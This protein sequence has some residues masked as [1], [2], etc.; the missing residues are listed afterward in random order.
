MGM[1]GLAK[2]LTGS[3]WVLGDPSRLIRI[4]LHGKEGEMLMPPFGAALADEEMAAVLTYI[5]R[6]WDHQ[7]S[8]IAPGQVQEVRGYT[9]GR[10]RP[11]TDEEL[12]QA[13]R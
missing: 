12:M 10:D 11:W 6:A 5:R 13:R 2:R 3:S 1:P 9:T 8:P 7:A 4:V